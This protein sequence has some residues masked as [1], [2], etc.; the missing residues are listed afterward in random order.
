MSEIILIGCSKRK[1]TEAAPAGEFYQGP[2]FR[3]ALEYSRLAHPDAKV[4]VLSAKYGIVNIDQVLEPYDMTL[5]TM[6]VADRRDWAKK[7]LDQM[8]D[9][10]INPDTDTFIVF[11]GKRYYENLNLVNAS[12]PLE[13][14]S[15]GY[16][17]QKLTQLINKISQ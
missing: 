4:Y 11:A 3:K 5:N 9:A 8:H 14:C 12:Y 1:A 2:G 6:R 13:G 15:Q 17:L 10:G 16:S 7:V